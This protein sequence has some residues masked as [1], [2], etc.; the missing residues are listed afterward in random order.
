MKFLNIPGTG[1]VLQK[2][3][4]VSAAQCSVQ[5]SLLTAQCSSLL[6]HC[7]SENA[8]SPTTDFLWLIRRR[9]SRLKLA[10][11]EVDGRANLAKRQADGAGSKDDVAVAMLL[12]IKRKIKL[13]NVA[14]CVRRAGLQ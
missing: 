8:S 14:K 3:G 1:F 2:A 10:Q 12:L 5:C 13:E 11:Q 9:W 4:K 7:A 6:T